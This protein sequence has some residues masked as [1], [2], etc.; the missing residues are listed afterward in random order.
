MTST[1]SGRQPSALRP[2]GW[3][4]AILYTHRWLGI[5]GGALFVVWFASGI[6]MLYARMP[7]LDPAERLRRMPALDLAGAR[8]APADAA[9]AAGLEAPPDRL[10]IA[11]IGGRPVYR[12]AAGSR[13]SVVFA[14][15]GSPLSAVAAGDALRIAR[16]LY[17]EH[18]ATLRHDGRLAEPDQWTLQSR[19]FL[20]AH[21]IALG[22]G[23]DTRI[24]LSERT[25]EPVMSTSRS[26]RRWAYAGA[27][28]HWL[29][30]TALRRHPTVWLQTVL[31]LAIGGCVLTASGLCWGLRQLVAHRR[32][33]A[34]H[35]QRR[36]RRDATETGSGEGGS[37]SPYAGWLRWHH[38]AGLVFGWFAF[39]WVL[40][41]ALSLE[42]WEWHPGTAPD[43]S[44]RL[45]VA[46]GALRLEDLTL[47]RLLGAHAA[48]AAALP[49][50]ELE[51]VQLAGEPFLAAQ[52]AP[53]PSR[54]RSSGA[55]TTGG[56]R[57]DET[58]RPRTA[59][60]YEVS[61]FL[62]PVQPFERR[63]V[64]VLQPE[65]GVF[66]RFADEAVLAAARAAMP[67]A[68]LLDAVWLDRHDAYYY[69]RA[70]ARPLPVLRARFDDEAGTWLYL[71]PALGAIVHRE[72]RRTRLNR[73]LY[74]GLHSLDLPFLRQR[75]GLRDA[76]AIVLCLGGILLAA[77]SMPDGWRRAG[78]H[79]RRAI[80][81]AA[82]RS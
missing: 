2:S 67:R 17:P 78:H 76:I 6:V 39:T 69:D 16:R 21:R 77:S 50:A 22:D 57:T 28:P 75:R 35:H 72:V 74:H 62:D 79:L 43:D 3:Q 7:S 27:V 33:V 36:A 81:A 26:R 63:L 30:V 31:W 54:D 48:L 53:P 18:A 46:G 70:G 24:Y 12:F 80:R 1:G 32:R 40:S 11:S 68:R 14:D 82:G 58:E 71:D 59:S 15:D 60:A 44:Q 4:R 45:M 23:E 56:R 19:A 25:G 66:E 5:A 49:V 42:P 41:G 52:R 9:R 10:R 8:V 51:L 13:W 65:R 64:P 34:G 38:Y 73:W 61:S 29:Y 20:P 55:T 47:E 37:G